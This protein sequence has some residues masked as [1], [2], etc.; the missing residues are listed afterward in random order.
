MSPTTTPAPE[1][2]T[3]ESGAPATTLSPSLTAYYDHLITESDRR[4]SQVKCPS[5]GFYTEAY[6]RQMGAGHG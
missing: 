2:K 1:V 4:R 6:N 5:A 3:T